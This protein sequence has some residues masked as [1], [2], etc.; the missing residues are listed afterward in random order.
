MVTWAI[1]DQGRVL[2]IPAHM[3][4]T[5]NK[6]NPRTKRQMIQEF[7]KDPSNEKIEK[8]P[9]VKVKRHRRSLIATECI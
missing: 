9:D 8:E 3:V 1:A 7:G 2:R 5:I 4:E 6:Y